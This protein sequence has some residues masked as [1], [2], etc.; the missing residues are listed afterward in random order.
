MKRVSDGHADFTVIGAEGAFKWVRGEL[1][2]LDLLFPVDDIVSAGWGISPAAGDLRKQL[3]SFFAESLRV[4]SDLDRAWQKQYGISRME[5]QLFEASF[6]DKSADLKSLLTLAVPVGSGF[7][8]V[9]FA[10]LFWGRRLKRE[11]AEHRHTEATLRALQATSAQESARRLAITQIQL[12]LQQVSSLEN[13]GQ[14][15]L[16]DLAKQIPVAQAIFCVWDT[17]TARLRA[18]AHYAG[19]GATPTESLGQFPATE[20]LTNECRI[21]GKPILIKQPGPDSLRFYIG[22][23]NCAPASI[24]IY[25]IGELERIYAV[26]ELATLKEIDADHM[27]LLDDLKPFIALSLGRLGVH[28]SV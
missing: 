28:G 27:Q 22:L 24:L 2:N 12:H 23:G 17:A 4:G 6:D 11:V 18:V 25:P 26:L 14:T 10:M 1:K 8:G 3:E 19:G 5:Y 15:L 13:F 7:V 9:I 16:S 21:T 20:G